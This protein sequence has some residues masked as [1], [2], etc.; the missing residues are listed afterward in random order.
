MWNTALGMPNLRQ[1]GRKEHHRVRRVFDGR[2]P[3]RRAKE[4]TYLE[5][6]SEIFTIDGD[7][8]TEEA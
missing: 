8:V 4:N 2:S 5:S 7:T 6:I 1:N 3:G